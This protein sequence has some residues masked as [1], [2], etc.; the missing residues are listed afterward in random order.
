MHSAL[1]AVEA[2]ADNQSP[3]WQNVNGLW[4][5]P[6]RSDQPS[7]LDDKETV[8][9]LAENV[10]LVNFQ[11]NPAALA[12]LIYGAERFR[13]SYKILPFEHE[14]EWLLGGSYPNTTQ[15]QTA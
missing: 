12:T 14:P 4:G 6:L 9:Q 13:L 10:W 1:F 11:M 3:A 2:P 8:Q 15:G 5:Q 7:A